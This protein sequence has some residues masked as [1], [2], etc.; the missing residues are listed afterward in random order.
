MSKFS[1]K[2][3][4]EQLSAA[5]CLWLLCTA[6][7]TVRAATNVVTSFADNGAGSLR[8]AL[9]SAANGDTIDVASITGT[10]WVT[11]GELLVSN[12]VTVLGPGAN[13]LAVN[14]YPNSR[15]FH[16]SNGV[17]TIAGL[18]ITDGRS[19][20]G[21]GIYNDHSTL[22]VINCNVS[23]NVAYDGGGIFNDGAN[24]GSAT[25]SIVN[26]TLNDN[27][28][29]N[30]DGGGIFNYGANG[31]SA[32]LS[33]L[34]CTFS[35]NLGA[36]GAMFNYGIQNGSVALSIRNSTL[37]GNS[38]TIQNYGAGGSATL[39]I[40]NTILKA[41]SG[42][43]LFSDSGSVTSL[44]Y[45]LSSDDGGGVLTNATDQINTDP[46]IG[47][48]Q[49]NGGPTRTHALMAGSPAIDKGTNFS[50]VASDQRSYP[51]TYDDPNVANTAGGD[52]TD[53][54]AYEASELRIVAVQK[55]GNDLRL[56][57][58]GLLGTNY[59]A[60]IRSNMTT[61]NWTSL[62]GTT[63]GNGGIASTTISNAFSQSRQFSRIRL[64][65]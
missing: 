57:F 22:T 20:I 62:A 42:A 11:S 61:D 7:L 18:T 64:V 37:S 32:T 55:A 31:G 45:N 59:E 52:G 24:G 1:R 8:Q 48:L 56:D 30:G 19:N 35:G 46:M 58:T 38:L 13:V 29:I 40:G 43:N 27:R 53:I 47:Q 63:P 6:T 39:E 36:G 9:A 17:V 5:T 10:I 3:V 16:I 54:G 33:I 2:R 51:R 65:P 49:G 41:G 26:S 4:V 44:G 14:S 50:S 15:V 21:A 28:V 60:Q 23:G 34:N 12:S 25:L